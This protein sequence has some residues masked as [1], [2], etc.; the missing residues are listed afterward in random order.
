[1]IKNPYFYTRSDTA[2][3]LNDIKIEKYKITLK[4]EQSENELEELK[5]N[6]AEKLSNNYLDMLIFYHDELKIYKILDKIYNLKEKTNIIVYYKKIKNLK[7][8]LNS[9]YFKYYNFLDNF[10]IE[11]IFKNIPIDKNNQIYLLNIL[12]G[13]SS[14]NSGLNLLTERFYHYLKMKK[15]IQDLIY[16]NIEIL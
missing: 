12:N 4:E 14:V 13:N 10:D 3:N 7:N 15:Y 11:I 9:K 1:M 8:I 2:L 5:L 6:L 16:K